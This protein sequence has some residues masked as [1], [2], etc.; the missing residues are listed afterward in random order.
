MTNQAKS[1][2]RRRET[3]LKACLRREIDAGL[4]A[5]RDPNNAGLPDLMPRT[6][7]MY[8]PWYTRT[9]PECKHKFREGDRVRLCPVCEQAYHDDNQYNLHC[10]QRHFAN[11]QI[12]TETR[13]DP[14]TDV[15]RPGCTYRWSGEL[16]EEAHHKDAAHHPSRRIG[17]MT[18]QFLRGLE[19]VWT[20]FGEEAV[21]E[22]PEGAVIVGHKCPWCRFQV[23]AGDRVVKCPCG[24]CNT[25]FHDD[26]FR[27]LTC[28]DEWNGS[29]GHDYCPTSGEKIKRNPDTTRSEADRDR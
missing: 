24:K 9:C 15:H 18:T 27:H 5:S 16:P 20:P 7:T 6:T 28:W 21:F 23:R 2:D 17:P 29:R 22:V 3:P 11:G 12:C 19:N 10:W 25:Y 26:I 4:A 8:S 1:K 14:I 13:L